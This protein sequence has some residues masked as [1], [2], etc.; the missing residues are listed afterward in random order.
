L[1]RRASWLAAGLVLSCSIGSAEARPVDRSRLDV[2]IAGADKVD[3]SGDPAGYLRIREDA[4]AEARRIFPAGH[5]EIAVREQEVATGLAAAQRFDEAEAAIAR[6]IPALRKAG[7][8]Y[9]QSMRDAIDL[10]GYIA[11]Y[12][13]DHAR[14]VALFEQEVASYR[15]DGRPSKGHAT[16]LS[17]LAAASWEAGDSSHALELNRAALDMASALDP[18]PADG[19]MWYA[20]RM[21]YLRGLGRI[22]EAIEA[23]Q[24]GLLYARGLVPDTH[25]L[26][27]NINANTAALLTQVGRP[28]AAL[29]LARRA[30]EAVEA[31]AGGP[32][33][34]SAAMRAI[35]AGALLKAGHFEEAGAFLAHAIPIIDAQLGAQSNRALQAREI[36]AQVL[37]RAGRHEEAIALQQQVVA[38]RDARLAAGHR[39]RMS[40]RATLARMALSAGRLELAETVQAEGVAMRQAVVPPSHP[41]LLVERSMLQLVRSR[42]G[43]RKPAEL[44]E[45]ARAILNL[46][47]A[48]ARRDPSAPMSSDTRLAFQ[49]MAEVLLRAGD[50]DA[51]FEAQQWSARTSVDDAAAAGAAERFV[52]GRPEAAALLAERRGRLAERAALLGKVE[53][54]MAAPDGTFDL[55]ATVER[56]AETDREIAGLDARLAALVPASDMARG[57]FAAVSVGEARQRLGPGE[58][59]VQVSPLFDRYLVTLITASGDA[60]YLTV[61]DRTALED[62]VRTLRATLNPAGAEVAFDRADAAAL[63]E[64]LFPRRQM[65][66]GVNRLRV[67]AG[68]A[69]GA[70]PFAVLVDRG[71]YLIDRMAISRVPGAAGLARS[72]QGGF[73]PALF[74]MG[75]KA[76]QAQMARALRGVSAGLPVLDPLPGSERELEAIAHSIGAADPVILLGNDATEAAL[77]A[78]RIVP[79]SVL[80]FATHALVSGEV[81]GLREPAL[82][83]AAHGPDDGLLTAGEIS[84][85]TLPAGWV[86]LSACN[87]AAG[88]AA[89]APGLS[90]LAQAFVLAGAGHILAS[91]W[92]V[93]DDVAGRITSRMMQAVARN[94]SP[95]DALREA[96]R[97]ARGAK[98]SG[99]P[100][101]WA[102]FELV[103]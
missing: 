65:L 62:K 75:A 3:P 53:A 48:N 15:A 14:A 81:E 45:E 10:R 67:S 38:A 61:A 96:M 29:P 37:S 82:V 85:M 33:Q 4:L 19:A 7:S 46:L 87:T 69:F 8:A 80:A 89:D 90:G 11:T 73:V 64:A 98:A 63:F 42:A 55:A 103:E 16:A 40:G 47:V 68:G 49:A 2:L 56:V 70:L 5:P 100:A 9:A 20:N 50:T 21:A 36:R 24:D 44:A 95:A 59:F 39:D 22:E 6:V 93:R 83:L 54:Q 97:A 66:R 13:G 17:N 78:A 27:A 71:R 28:N 41:D 72:A 77:R 99:H 23:G 57:R 74:G 102:A 1:V 101:A 52:A 25:P 51:A 58:A 12:R 84:R 79:G 26:L 76:G 34:N 30:F 92:P 18:R 88:S 60:Q 91:H 94:A 32:N 86:L 35:F 43:S 31:A